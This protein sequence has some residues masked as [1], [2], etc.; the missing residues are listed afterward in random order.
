MKSNADIQQPCLTPVDMLK[1]VSLLP[2]LHV[3]L[4]LQFSMVRTI[5]CEIPYALSD[6]PE[7]VSCILLKEF[8]KSAI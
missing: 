6:A 8:L 4:P 1:L 7:T 3:K 5:S 2:T